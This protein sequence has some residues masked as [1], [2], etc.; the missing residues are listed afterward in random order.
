MQPKQRDLRFSP[1]RFFG[2]HGA[3]GCS[4]RRQRQGGSSAGGAVVGLTSGFNRQRSSERHR[5]GTRT[6]ARAVDHDSLECRHARHR[7]D[8]QPHSERRRTSTR[9]D[10]GTVHQHS[11]DQRDARHRGGRK[12][13]PQQCRGT[14]GADDGPVRRRPLRSGSDRCRPATRSG[15]VADRLGHGGKLGGDPATPERRGSSSTR[16]SATAEMFRVAAPCRRLPLHEPER[17]QAGD[18]ISSHRWRAGREDPRRIGTPGQ[19]RSARGGN[20]AG[21]RAETGQ[22]VARSQMG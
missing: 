14:P 2:K 15:P 7:D 16:P 21:A 19:R 17:D 9:A 6:N 20:K 5:P 8:R 3:R 4:E 11:L 18:I 22:G 13:H 12:P 10:T 1:S